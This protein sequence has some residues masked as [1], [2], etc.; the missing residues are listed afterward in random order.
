MHTPRCHHPDAKLA[1]TT[2]RCH[3]PDVPFLMSNLL[4]PLHDASFPMPNLLSLL[5]DANYPMPNF[6][7]HYP[8]PQPIHKLT[9][10]DG[11][12]PLPDGHFMIISAQ[13]P[14][15][16]AR[17]AR[18]RGFQTPKAHKNPDFVLRKRGIGT[19]D[20][21]SALGSIIMAFLQITAHASKIQMPHNQIIN[22]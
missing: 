7:H 8:M 5:Y 11:H 1:A 20:R 13:K 4:P 19:R 9:L 15:F 3:L 2:T 18:K 6:C 16:C 17:N 21:K 10:P 12:L 22:F 14:R